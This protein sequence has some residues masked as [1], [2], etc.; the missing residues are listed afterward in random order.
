MTLNGSLIYSE[1]KALEFGGINLFDENAYLSSLFSRVGGGL[2]VGVDLQSD[3]AFIKWGGLRATYGSL[4]PSDEKTMVLSLD[5]HVAN[6]SE[7]NIE[8]LGVAAGQ[9]PQ[10]IGALRLESL[11]DGSVDL[12]LYADQVLT[13]KANED[14]RLLASMLGFLEDSLDNLV[15]PD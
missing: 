9:R 4:V 6:Y 11:E 13:L 12:I 10:A 14:T 15:L 3:K 5:L 7:M 8:L 1:G 2:E